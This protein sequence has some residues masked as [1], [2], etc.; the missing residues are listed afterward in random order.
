MRRKSEIRRPLA[1]TDE[2]GH[3]TYVTMRKAVTRSL[4]PRR[5]SQ[6]DQ[7]DG[8]QNRYSR[9]RIPSRPPFDSSRFAGL[10]H[11]LRF[12]LHKKL[13]PL[14]TE[15]ES[16]ASSERSESRGINYSYERNCF[17][18]KIKDSNQRATGDFTSSWF[19]YWPP[20]N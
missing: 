20:G 16:N 14:S 13:R 10:A 2:T 8:L 15:A 1:R 19:W 17:S 12:L 9:V 18:A 3:M 5:R 6:V 4:V 11:G 7:G